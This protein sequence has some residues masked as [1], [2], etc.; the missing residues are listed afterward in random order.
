M[1]VMPYGIQCM[2][3]VTMKYTRARKLSYEI[4]GR[5]LDATNLVGVKESY[6][7]GTLPYH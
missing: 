4:L 1:H 3:P 5:T 7:P 6:F 2:F